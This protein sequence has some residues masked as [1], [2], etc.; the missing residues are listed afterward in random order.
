MNILVDISLKKHKNGDPAI[1]NFTFL[2]PGFEFQ[3]TG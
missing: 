2:S 3:K 1:V